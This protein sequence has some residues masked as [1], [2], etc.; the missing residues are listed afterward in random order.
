LRCYTMNPT[1]VRSISAHPAASAL[2]TPALLTPAL[3]T[4]ARSSLLCSPLLSSPL[5]TP[6]RKQ[7]PEPSLSAI[8]KATPLGTS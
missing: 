8:R 1:P 2:L 4:P 5:L 6:H 7:G 3:L